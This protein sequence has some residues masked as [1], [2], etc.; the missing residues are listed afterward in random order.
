MKKYIVALF[1]FSFVFTLNVQALDVSAKG[2]VLING[3]TGEMLYSKN[4][5]WQLPMASTTKIMTALLLAQE[6]TPDKQIV[7]TKEMVT[8]EGSSMGLLPGDI[9]TYNDLLYGMLLASGNDA[10]NVT[11]YALC[12]S[13]VEFAAAMN[14]K[15]REI[16]L[17]HTNFVTPSGLDHENHY[18]TARELALLTRYAMENEAFANAAASKTATLCYGNPPYK[19]SLR[20]HNKLL[21]SYQGLIGVKTGF[22]KKSGRCLVTAAKRGE[23]YLIAVTLNDPN[24]WADH[25]NMLNFGFS[26]LTE[27][28]IKYNCPVSS[29]PVVGGETDNVKI[30]CN[31]FKAGL[32]DAEYK[33]ITMQAFLPEFVYAPVS[34]GQKIGYTYFY[35][36]GKQI[37]KADIITQSNVNSLELEEEDLT[38]KIYK[39]FVLLVKQFQE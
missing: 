12:G 7:T 5:N 15:A 36:G 30:S 16:G 38:L 24:D 11:A 37:G 23:K 20:N 2:A 25:T 34:A 31:N 4:E 3:T 21:N 6:N 17:L 1:L 29:V 35:I 32:T 13:P 27:R 26:V 18:T 22:T 8:V 9:V 10:A 19:R 14:K 33:Q 28:E 39:K